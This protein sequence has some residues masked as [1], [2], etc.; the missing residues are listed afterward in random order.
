MISIRAMLWKRYMLKKCCL[1]LVGLVLFLAIGRAGALSGLRI[2]ALSPQEVMGM[3]EVS[4]RFSDDSAIFTKTAESPQITRIGD[5]I[6]Y[7]LS[8]RNNLGT[9]QSVQISD[10]LPSNVSLVASSLPVGLSYDSVSRIVMGSPVIEPSMGAEADT[11]FGY[12][13]LS[14]SL[15]P[16]FCPAECDDDEYITVAGLDF[17]FLG[18][19]RDR[20]FVN[21]NGFVSVLPPEEGVLEQ[22]PQALPDAGAPN[23]VIAPLWADFNLFGDPAIDA[24]GG[25]EIYVGSISISGDSRTWTVIEWKEVELWGRPD[26]KFSF[27]LWIEDGSDNM[28]FVYGPLGDMNLVDMAGGAEGAGAVFGFNTFRQIGGSSVGTV[29]SQGDTIR[30]TNGAGVEYSFAVTVN[31]GNLVTNSAVI[32][33]NDTVYESTAETSVF[34]NDIFLPMLNK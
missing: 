21:P 6:T 32:A 1:L 23:G 7:K 28:W 31:S 18:V 15:D 13:T 3:R 5:V 22:S 9:P 14:G 33:L 25:G 16:Q 30:L 27:Q 8:V 2:S 20:V 10:P 34:N 12:Q 24:D 19:Q 4:Q 17:E 26:Q 11:L 29:P